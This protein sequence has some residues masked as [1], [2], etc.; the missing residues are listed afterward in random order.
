[1]P[2]A[3]PK[4]L[5]KLEQTTLQ[6]LWSSAAPLSVRDVMKRLQRRPPLAYTTVL[7]V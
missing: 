3:E 4:S 6:V 7:T 2:K 1:M 5:G